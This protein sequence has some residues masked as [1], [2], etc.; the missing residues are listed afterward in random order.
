V[1]TTTPKAVSTP[2]S[3]TVPSKWLRRDTGR[4]MSE[5]P[6]T[7]DLVERW[8]QANEAFVRRDFDAMMSFFAPDAVWDLSSAGIG[9]FEGTAA[10]RGF[11]EDWIAPMGTMRTKWRLG[12]SA[13][14]RRLGCF[15]WTLA[16]LEVR[17][18][19]GHSGALR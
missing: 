4:V 14:T 9:R 3:L 7:P 15:P 18:G 16:P 13:T 6:T 5:E 1:R 8:R 17:A 2:T 19:C 12:T 11:H 10:I